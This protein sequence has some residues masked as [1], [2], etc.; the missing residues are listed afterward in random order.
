LLPALMEVAVGTWDTLA[1]EAI[2]GIVAVSM[3]GAE[4]PR[5]TAVLK[6]VALQLELMATTWAFA[7]NYKWRCGRLGE[8]LRFAISAF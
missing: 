1:S 2:S 4:I 6:P 3:A 7:L 8:E 5:S